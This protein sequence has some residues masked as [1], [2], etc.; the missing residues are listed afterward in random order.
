MW[1]SLEPHMGLILW[2]ALYDGVL[3]LKVPNNCKLIA[4]AQDLLN[5][6]ID[7]TNEAHIK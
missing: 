7:K 3:R 5:V 4:F 6:V 1:R 2:N